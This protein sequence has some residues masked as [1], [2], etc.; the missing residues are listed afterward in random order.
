MH[1]VSLR[2]PDE[3][4]ERLQALAKNTGRSKTYYITEAIKLH[5][6]DLEDIYIAERMIERV[7][8][9]KEEIVSSEEVRKSLELG[10]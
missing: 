4:G 7:R 3:L 6:E 2:L 5:L 10:N 9:G 8:S 1:S